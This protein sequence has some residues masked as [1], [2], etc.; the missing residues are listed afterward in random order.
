MYE[1]SAALWADMEY[2]PCRLMAGGV[3]LEE[4]EFSARWCS[5]TFTLGSV[6]A[7]GFS[8]KVTAREAP[9]A[10]GDW[11]ALSALFGEFAVPLG[12]FQITS[13]RVL[14]DEGRY[15]LTGSDAV[16][17]VLEESFGE[18]GSVAAPELY[19]AIAERCGLNCV[20][21]EGIP[22]VEVRVDANKT[23]R[24]LLGEIALLAGGNVRVD[25]QG[26]LRLE[27]LNRVD[28]LLDPTDYYES[29]LELDGV[30]YVL[31]AMQVTAGEQV[32]PPSRRAASGDWRLPANAIPK[33]PLTGC[34]RPGQ[35]PGSVR[36]A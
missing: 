10:Q 11:V 23:M 21:G 19:G 30:D 8:A 27:G 28:Y 34:G 29:E 36:A 6:C 17:T 18:E 22:P 5:G 14:T 26:V 7:A 20:G 4:G 33:A 15:T 3:E 25:R 32:F 12:Q 35:A 2:A 31:G 16:G 13:I 24:T 1:A 9:F